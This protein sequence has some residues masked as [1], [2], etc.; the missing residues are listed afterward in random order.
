MFFP[1]RT[2]EGGTERARVICRRCVV[3]E[4]CLTFA[5]ENDEQHGVWGGLSR[6]ERRLL[7]NP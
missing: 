1:Y 2:D 4:Q 3:A 7:V 5:N 6:S